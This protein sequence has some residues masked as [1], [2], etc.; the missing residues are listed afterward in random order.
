MKNEAEKILSSMGITLSEAFNMLLHQI[1]LKKAMPF[2]LNI[3]KDYT[4]T[5]LSFKVR[6]HIEKFES[7]KDE[8]NGPYSSLEELWDSMDI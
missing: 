6:E 1:N 3:S 4:M 8:L 7:G 5:D 2:N